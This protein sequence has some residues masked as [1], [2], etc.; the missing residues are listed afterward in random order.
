MESNK[1]IIRPDKDTYYWLI[2]R[3]VATRSTCR[4]VEHG[5]IIVRNDQIIATG[6][7]GAPRGVKD[8]LDLGFCIRR[9]KGIPSGTGYEMCRSAHAEMNAIINAARAGVSL[10]GGDLYIYSSRRTENSEVLIDA[11]PCLLCKKMI[12]NAGL[13]R[14]VGNS[15]DG[16]LRSYFISDWVED[17][18]MLEDLTQ[19]KEKYDAGHVETRDLR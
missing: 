14:V 2:A 1:K 15:K 11:Y 6:Y 8:C 18:K 5:A 9:Q 3:T 13:R 16:S 12:I 10:L 7:V 17:W 19:D 4:T